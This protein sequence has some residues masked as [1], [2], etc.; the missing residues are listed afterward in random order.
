MREGTR[1]IIFRYLV[2]HIP[3]GTDKMVGTHDISEEI[4]KMLSTDYREEC[5]AIF[6]KTFAEYWTEGVY[7]ERGN[8]IVPSEKK[9]AETIIE[10][11][12]HSHGLFKSE[13]AALEWAAG[14]FYITEMQ[15][16]VNWLIENGYIREW[17]KPARF[18]Y[19]WYLGVTAKG[20]EIAHLYR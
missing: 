17:K 18:G 1:K 12:E 10:A 2:S 6:L 8:A 16:G 7:D 20:W 11:C 5:K 13:E 3:Q 19:K 4:M 9:I 15:E 14:T